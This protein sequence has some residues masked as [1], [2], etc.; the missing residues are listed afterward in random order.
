MAHDVIVVGGGIAGCAAAERL[1]GQGLSVLLLERGALA[2]GATGRNQGGLLPSPL[3]ACGGLFAEA[4][5]YYERAER[6][7]EVPF[8]FRPHGYLL[9]AADEEG[10]DRARGHGHALSEVGF[11]AHEVG[12]RELRELEPGLASDLAGA[13]AV[14]GAHA[15]HPVLAATALAGRAARAGAEIRTHTPVRGLTADGDR[16][17][18]VVTDDGPLMAGA[19]VLAAGPWSRSLAQQ[20]GSDV[21]VFGARGWLLRTAPVT[22]TVFRHTLMQ[23]TWHGPVGLKRNGPPLLADVAAPAPT[24]TQVVFSLQPLPGGEVVLGSSSGPALQ[25]DDVR[26]GEEAVARIAAAAARHAPVLAKTPVRAAWSGVRPMSPDGLPM[27]GPAPGAP[28]LW[29]LTGF[30]IDGMPLAPG[31]A[32]LLTE[33]L[34]SGRRPTAAEP[35]A[36][37]RFAE[38]G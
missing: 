27:V 18:G 35:F 37:E 9:V 4:V 24:A 34:M 6:E 16:V 13:V 33:Y 23:S 15:L 20:A 3:P 7:S 30:G 2:G 28:G 29:L 8:R 21:P 5:A 14:E 31:T 22:G 11:P 36:P 19:V 38:D 17:T 32:R 26:D 1:A 10:M 12:P 25:P